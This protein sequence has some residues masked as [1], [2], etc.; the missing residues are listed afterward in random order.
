MT[1]PILK[2]PI[3]NALQRKGDKA[4]KLMAR[5]FAEKIDNGTA[6]PIDYALIA[7]LLHLISGQGRTTTTQ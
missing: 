6:T 1:K 4:V 2:P 5:E 7:D 3:S